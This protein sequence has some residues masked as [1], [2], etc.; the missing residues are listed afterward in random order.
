MESLDSFPFLEARDENVGID[1][2]DNRLFWRECS[3]QPLPQIWRLRDQVSRQH[4]LLKVGDSQVN[5]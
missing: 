1:L 2:T 5:W 3:L 4:F